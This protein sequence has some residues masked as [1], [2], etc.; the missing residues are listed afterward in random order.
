M[1]TAK[2]PEDV[3]PSTRVGRPPRRSP[4]EGI[5]EAEQER[6]TWQRARLIT[7]ST[8]GF[9]LASVVT[10]LVCILPGSVMSPGAR[11][12]A[13]VLLGCF[14]ASHIALYLT[15]TAFWAIS[16]YCVGSA[17]M[18]TLWNDP[19]MGL[20]LAT[21]TA[22]IA[23]GGWGIGSMATMLVSTRG[24]VA[25]LIALFMVTVFHLWIP[26]WPLGREIIAPTILLVG[27]WAIPTAFGLWLLRTFPRSMRRISSIGRAYSTERRAS[28]SE[29]QRHRDARLLHDTVLATLSLLAHSGRGVSEEAMRAQAASDRDLLTRLR[30]G[31][32]V[33]PSASGAYSLTTADAASP[34]DALGPVRERFE[35]VGLNVTWHGT[36]EI[37]ASSA[38]GEAFILAIGECLENVRRHSGVDHADVTLS[39]TAD[40]LRAVVTDSGVGFDP[41]SI[42]SGRLGF[43]ESVV[44]RLRSVGGS[45]RVFSAPGAGTTIMLEVP[46][47]G[48]GVGA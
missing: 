37:D 9:A 36:G 17:L 1:V 28:E 41:D 23:V 15:Q 47:P 14:L 11:A 22:M 30:L 8:F 43:A 2:V 27:A 10:T 31:E 4:G 42:D 35:R 18:L 33:N 46:A 3:F 25:I 16:T 45:T 39:A 32:D 40:L 7:R 19:G 48:A 5:S 20:N 26:L 21:V 38:A 24:H 12:L 13:L 34:G 29:A 44:G 6:F